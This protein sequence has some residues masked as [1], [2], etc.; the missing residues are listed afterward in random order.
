M[1]EGGGRPGFLLE[2]P[3]RV[4][5]S[6]QMRRQHFQRDLAVEARVARAIDFAHAARSEVRDDVV[7]AE[8][9]PSGEQR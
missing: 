1:R 8:T 4:V 6:R 9:G 2:A 5:V 7:R 3:P